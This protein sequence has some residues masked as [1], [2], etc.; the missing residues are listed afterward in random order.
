MTT[1]LIV[2]DSHLDLRLI[3]GLLSREAEWCL[4]LAEHGGQALEMIAD[5][6]PDLVITD[7]IMPEVDGLQLVREVRAKFPHIPVILMTAYGN[8]SIAVE[9]LEQGAASYV[10]KAR[11]A[12]CLAE[13]V[14]RVLARTRADRNRQHM[15]QCLTHMDCTFS[16]ESVP[17]LIPPLV[18]LVQQ[19]LSGMLR[20]D[21]TARMRVGLAVEEALL[22]ALYHGNLE[23]SEEELSEARGSLSEGEL[24]ALVESRRGQPAYRDRKIIFQVRLSPAGARFVVRDGGPGFDPRS[25]API[26]PGDRF[27]AGKARGMTLMQA[28]V[29]EVLYNDTGN[30]VQ[31]FVRS[32]PPAAVV[33]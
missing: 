16:L 22:N 3:S 14:R 13:T 31:L 19:M 2:D 23:M 27:E 29:D 5:E 6:Q 17:A 18:D 20:E 15:M 25:T 33:S 11:Q 32:A 1:I 21:A 12:E 26:S 28:L 24:T 8:E 10:P 9:A 30:E 4:Q 7:L